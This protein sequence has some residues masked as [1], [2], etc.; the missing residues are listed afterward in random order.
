MGDFLDGRK[1]F[2]VGGKSFVYFYSYSVY[3]CRRPRKLFHHPKITHNFWTEEKQ[4]DEFNYGR[5]G[6]LPKKGDLSAPGNYRGI[7]M[8]EI[9]QKNLEHHENPP[10][11]TCGGT[12]SQITIW[13]PPKTRN[14]RCY[15]YPQDGIE[16]KKIT[17]PRIMGSFH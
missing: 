1:G 9:G 4:P 16:K 6:I 14:G 11:A 5:L 15:L 3:P 12:R 10:G 13:F 17:Q 7:M 8:L 2:G